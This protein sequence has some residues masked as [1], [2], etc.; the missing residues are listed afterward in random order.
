MKTVHAIAAL[1]IAA[2]ACSPAVCAET[3]NLIFATTEPAGSDD[4]MRVFS[5]WAAQIA[6]ATSDAIHI[7]LREGVAIANATNIYDRVQS[8]V[9]Q[10]GILIPSLIGGKFPLTDVVG[11]P[12]VT[13]DSVNASVA[14]WRLYKTGVFDTEYKNIVPLGFGLFPPQDVQLVKAPPTLDNLQGLRLRVVGKLSSELVE[15]LGGTPLVL[16]PSDQYTALER[17]TIDGVLSSWMSM[18]PLHLI[19]VTGYHVETSLGTGMFIV[20]MARGKFDSLPTATREGIL[21]NS[22][23]SLSRALGTGFEARA[24]ASRANAIADPAKHTV[25]QLPPA[26]TKAWAAAISPVIDEWT[27]S[28]AGGAALLANYR[29]ILAEVTAGK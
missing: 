7:D 29:R 1:A 19:D 16:D 9:V 5:P 17:H 6:K 13:Q 3:T 2:L 12:F 11:L 8:D 20:F 21:A 24:T 27:S 15:R 23:E 26:Q 10:V 25:V 4:S 22:G 18:G 28:H 14:F